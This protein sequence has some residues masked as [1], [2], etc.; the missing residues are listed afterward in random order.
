MAKD[1]TQIQTE[2]EGDNKSIS[3]PTTPLLSKLKEKKMQKAKEKSSSVLENARKRRKKSA[4][5]QNLAPHIDFL[6]MESGIIISKLDYILTEE[7]EDA[8]V[9]EKTKLAKQKKVENAKYNIKN[10][11]KSKLQTK[12]GE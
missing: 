7:V 4:K 10:R 12:I 6:P 8:Y 2:E 11:I 9:F 1:L 3:L 5:I